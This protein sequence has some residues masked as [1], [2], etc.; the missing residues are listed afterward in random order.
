MSA[1][2][3]PEIPPGPQRDLN[4]ALH[5]LHHRAGW[6]SLRVLAAA[7]GCSHTT[8]STV[9]S[10]SRLP[11]W[12]TLELLVEAMGG[13]TDEFHRLWLAAGEPSSDPDAVHRDSPR[14]AG[15][16]TELAVVRRH[17][18]SGTGL[19]LVIGEAGIGKTTLVDA[20]RATTDVFVA[21]GN[22]LPLSVPAPLLP[23]AAA[24]HEVYAEDGGRWL[25]EALAGSPAYVATTLTPLLSELETEAAPVPAPASGFAQ[26]RLFSAVRSVLDALAGVRP[27]ALLLEDLHWADSASLDL[28]EHLVARGLCVPVVGTF[29]LEDPATR[30]RT[31]DWFARIR[32]I[33]DVRTIE[34]SALSPEETSEQISL[35][36]PGATDD[37]AASIYERSLGLP[38]FTEQ[39][40]VHSAGSLPSLLA[41]VLDQRLEQLEGAPYAVARALGIAD[42]TVPVAVLC[43]ATGLHAEA[44]VPALRDLRDRHLLAEA[45]PTDVA[46]RHPLLAEA[47]RRRLVAG[48]AADAHHS[49]AAALAE[50]S[51]ADAAEVAEHW[52]RAGVLDQELTWR[53]VAAERAHLRTAPRTESA[54]WLRALE[55]ATAE[56]W[57]ADD[58]DVLDVR[59][60]AFDALDL[61]GRVADACRVIDEALPEVDVLDDLRAAEVLRRAA[62][63]KSMSTHDVHASVWFLDRAVS[64]LDGHGP[65]DC[66]ARALD[67]RANV[68]LEVGRPEEARHDLERALETCIALDDDVLFFQTSATLAWQLA[69][70]GDLPGALER[71]REA[72]ARVPTPAEPRVE[73]YVAM[74]HTDLLLRYHR[75]VEEV[76]AAAQRALEIGAEWDMDFH[77]LSFVGANVAE[78]LADAGRIRQA[79]EVLAGI[80][81]LGEFDHWPVQWISARIAVE[82][83]RLDDALDLLATLTVGTVP[84][85]L[86]EKARLTAIAHL[87]KGAPEEAWAC[88]LPPIRDIVGNAASRDAGAAF[89]TA[90]RVAADLARRGVDPAELASVLVGLRGEAA[91][92]PLGPGTAPPVRPATSATWTAELARLAGTDTPQQWVAAA[93]EW[94]ALRSPHEAAYCRWRGGQAAYAGRQAT[95]AQRLLRRAA[96]EAREHVPLSAAI[97][98]TGRR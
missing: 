71:I 67:L 5:D 75:P 15:R 34:L 53:V 76:V 90:A 8:V 97:A 79:A 24:L 6:P 3:R 54:Q 45:G 13:D 48:E 98:A 91:V 7:A 72:H 96:G 37:E 62:M 17:L 81:T 14:I 36:V 74:T 16:R 19:L 73:A 60:K 4:A 10:S 25:K 70:H 55:I 42:R 82:S 69:Y 1:L 11:G 49:L 21:R 61:A 39:L 89:M 56:P 35:L 64:R 88:L 57:A 46:L 80:P 47:V 95:L 51:D 84:G 77:V 28:L 78:S 44:L 86:L 58:L 31:R 63:G 83:G 41:D 52:Q 22:A 92:D 30:D 38:L 2:P 93:S 40:A 32:R 87:W 43:A 50:R 68:L 65:S 9:F 33:A 23:F 12:G 18:D 66:L 20:A 59:L 94:D 85:N 27:L 26:E 29:R